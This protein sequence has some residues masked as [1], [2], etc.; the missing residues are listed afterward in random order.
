[1]GPPAAV[2]LVSPV[3][4]M[5]ATADGKGYWLAAADGGVFTF[6]DAHFYGSTGGHPIPDWVAGI[7]ATHDGK[8]YWLANSDGAVYRFGDAG[9]YGNNLSAPRTEPIAAIAGDIGQPGVLAA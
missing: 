5:A 8:G 4:G 7:A 9:F 2:R 6:G 1:M 3:I